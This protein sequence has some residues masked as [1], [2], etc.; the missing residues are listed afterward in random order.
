MEIE[1]ENSRMKKKPIYLLVILLIMSSL[2]TACSSGACLANSWPG[3]TVDEGRE[4]VYVAYQTFVY[5]L[6]SSNGTERWRYPEKADNK[7]SF[8]ASP[9]LTDGGQLVAGSYD[10]NL[11]SL[12]PDNG[13]LQWT[14]ADAEN[15]YIASSLSTDGLILAPNADNLLYAVNENGERVWDFK[16]EHSLWGT[17]ASNGSLVYVPSMDR[18][19][20]ALDRASGS[21]QWTTE[22]LG[23]ALVAQPVLNSDGLLYVGTFGNEMLALDTK[24]SGQIIWRAETQ[25]W[26]WSP[27]LLLDGKLYFG[28]LSGTLYALD[29]KTG[30]ETWR[31][32]PANVVK[33]AVSGTPVVLNDVIYFTTEG[34]GLFALDLTNGAQKWM[35]QFEAQF[36]PGPIV[37]G[38]TLLLAPIGTDELVIALDAVG[39]QKW[40]FIPAK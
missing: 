26:V 27:P 18:K 5:A 20:Y 16:T 31:Y 35:K 3:L 8:Y 1:V 2:L 32:T 33:P 38:D 4:T 28:D 39:N 23:G 40:T 12:S 7:I 10:F 9:T 13:A 34:G 30:A 29:A 36:Y 6:N 25:G 15:R 14:F 24:K 37:A 11:Y 19:I 21:L 22:D 17:P